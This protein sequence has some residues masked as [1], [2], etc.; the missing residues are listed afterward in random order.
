MH[1]SHWTMGCMCLRNRVLRYHKAHRLYHIK[2]VREKRSCLRKRI[3]LEGWLEGVLTDPP[4]WC[5]Q[6]G[7]N[8]SDALCTSRQKNK[9]NWWD[10]VHQH[11]VQARTQ[12]IRKHGHGSKTPSGQ[13]WNTSTWRLWWLGSSKVLGQ[14]LTV[15]QTP[16]Q[17]SV[18]FFRPFWQQH[19]ARGCAG[20]PLKLG[21]VVRIVCINFYG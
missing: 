21:A 5:I 11:K 9:K 2:A 4:Q 20:H 15:E 10:T 1:S 3:S 7:S 12:T 8:I 14:Y 17:P 19:T 6:G 18:F 13:F 16:D